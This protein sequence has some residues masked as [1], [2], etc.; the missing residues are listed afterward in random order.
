M[1]RIKT[2]MDKYA[3]TEEGRK[4]FA[5]KAREEKKRREKRHIKA[6]HSIL[7]GSGA[8]DSNLW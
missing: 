5:K 6:E 1:G 7:G 3:E 2:A 4:L 8:F